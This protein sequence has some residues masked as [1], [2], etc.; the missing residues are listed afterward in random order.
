MH[1]QV[2]ALAGLGGP[3]TLF[4][5]SVGHGGLP[6][7]G[8]AVGSGRPGRVGT[9]VRSSKPAA[10]SPQPVDPSRRRA[11]RPGGAAA[12]PVQSGLAARGWADRMIGRSGRRPRVT[13]SRARGRGVRIGYFDCFSGI[14]GD[15]TLGGPGRCRGRPAARSRR[16]SASL[17]LP[18]RADVRDGP[19]R[20]LP[21]D[22]REGRRRRT[23]TPIAT[24][25]TSRRSSTRA[26]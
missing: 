7:V 16:P 2:R 17:G 19:P 11:V 13:A 14:S 23:S 24:C 21:R 25:T 5:V 8:R 26:R 6:R 18:V 10:G 22:L 9:T 1:A 20:R 12:S 4:V 15:M 3:I